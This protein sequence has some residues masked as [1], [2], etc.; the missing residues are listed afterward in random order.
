VSIAVVIDTPTVGSL[1]G[2]TV[3]APV[4]QTVAQQV[5]EYLGVP[6][7]Q[8]I[9]TS[10]QLLAA[11]S[12]STPDD[13]PSEPLGDLNAMYDAVN[14]LPTDDPLRVSFTAATDA[15]ATRAAAPAQ[16]V[17][18][19]SAN[20]QTAGTAM[21]SRILGLLPAKALALFNANGGTTSVMPDSA[22]GNTS[23]PRVS[24][25]APQVQPRSNGSVVVD[26]GERVSVP[27]FS[28][29]DLR[30]VVETA[31]G[32]GLRVE[33]VGSGL[34]REQAP[35]AGTQVPLGTAVVVRFTR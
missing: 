5:L 34:A 32:L 6:H 29:S 15:G 17:N 9:K 16:P 2:A 13:G 30:N 28:G 27:S 7:D 22:A 3:S 26:A 23:A 33:P 20:P 10:K 8:P 11:T 18:A 4:F 25:V 12:Q 31:A 24:M 35:A 14:N 21:T 1:Y 19:S